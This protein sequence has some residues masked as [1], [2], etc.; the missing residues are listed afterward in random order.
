MLVNDAHSNLDAVGSLHHTFSRR[1]LS[2]ST[3]RRKAKQFSNMGLSLRK[4]ESWEMRKQITPAEAE[5]GRI[6]MKRALDTKAKRVNEEDDNDT[7]SSEKSENTTEAKT[8]GKR[9]PP[10][11][12]LEPHRKEYF[13]ALLSLSKRALVTQ[14]KPNEEGE[15]TSQHY[16]DWTHEG[17]SKRVLDDDTSHEN[18]PSN[19]RPKFSCCCRIFYQYQWC[20]RLGC[21]VRKS[22]PTGPYLTRFLGGYGPD[23]PPIHRTKYLKTGSSKWTTLMSQPLYRLLLWIG[24][25]ST[26]LLVSYGIIVMVTVVLLFSIL[27]ANQGC[28]GTIDSGGEDSSYVTVGLITLTQLVGGGTA[29]GTVL[30]DSPSCALAS[31]AISTLNVGVRAL[32]F[33]AG[34]HSLTEV[35]SEV[36]FSSK[37]CVACRD[38]VPT[39]LARFGFPSAISANLTH[40]HADLTMFVKTKEG[41]LVSRH[42]VLPM[43]GFPSCNIPVTAS[44]VISKDS[45]LYPFIKVTREGLIYKTSS[46]PDGFITVHIIVYDSTTERYARRFFVCPLDAMLLN[47]RFMGVI[48][49]GIFE[50]VRDGTAV[51]L[52]HENINRTILQE[53]VLA[54]LKVFIESDDDD[55]DNSVAS[56][57][58]ELRLMWHGA[59]NK[60]KSKKL[61]ATD[62]VERGSHRRLSGF[63]IE[64]VGDHAKQQQLMSVDLD[65]IYVFELLERKKYLPDMSEYEIESLMSLIH[66][67]L[68]GKGESKRRER[69]ATDDTLQVSAG[70]DVQ[71]MKLYRHMKNWDR[72]D[73]IRE[74]DEW[75]KKRA[76]GPLSC[77]AVMCRLWSCSLCENANHQSF[78]YHATRAFNGHISYHHKRSISKHST[79]LYELR[80]CFHQGSLA[81]IFL[82]FSVAAVTVAAL[83]A[84]SF[85]SG[86]CFAKMNPRFEG[87][88]EYKDLSNETSEGISNHTRPTGSSLYISF[89]QAVTSTIVQVGTG[90][91]SDPLR[92]DLFHCALM[93]MVASIFNVIMR[94]LVFSAFLHAIEQA[95]PEVQFTDKIICNLREGVPVLQVRAVAEPCQSLQVQHVSWKSTSSYKSVEGEVYFKHQDLEV[96]SPQFVALPLTMTHRLDEKCP[97]AHYFSQVGSLPKGVNIVITM[98]LWDLQKCRY[99]Q[100]MR[101]YRL[102]TDLKVDYVFANTVQNTLVS[103]AK[104]G[105][106]PSIDLSKFNSLVFQDRPEEKESEKVESTATDSNVDTKTEINPIQISVDA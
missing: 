13:S 26:Q 103:A 44:H 4:I 84:I 62:I 95:K 45:A 38:G 5:L 57:K 59:L 72:S 58:S 68:A 81:S 100:V 65:N 66:R 104:N 30:T 92:H 49:V 10:A 42:E 101:V 67:A 1:V 31:V 33:A 19:F 79:L 77:G 73:F 7:L 24:F 102:T 11:S 6:M 17:V 105:G 46:Y 54:L 3:K 21:M 18:H 89:G 94:I 64:A 34:L 56:L 28:V 47:Q 96:H 55:V 2:I 60:V 63:A 75:I 39:I 48:D 14:N 37:L 88:Q 90:I 78:T 8:E 70:L 71:S 91:P 86:N 97:I 87:Y 9:L 43:K 29:P 69:S 41:R 93:I 106:A 61:P 80:K 82:A 16:F 76:T 36:V 27:Y 12:S 52:R 50:A 83:L 74:E 99:F 22:H 20:L 23:F 32:I 25:A 53:H 15:K 85:Q 51:V 98:G 35:E 40:I